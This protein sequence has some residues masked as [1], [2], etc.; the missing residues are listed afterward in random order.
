MLKELEHRT[1]K[2]TLKSKCEM[3][4]KLEI[5]RTFQHRNIN[6]IKK[7]EFK[8]QLKIGIERK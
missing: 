2:E 6:L 5:E 8:G 1:C 7:S 3:N 4:V